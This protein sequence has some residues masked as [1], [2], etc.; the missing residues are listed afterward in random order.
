MTWRRMICLLALAGLIVAAL[1]ACAQEDTPAGTP[2]I[3]PITPAASLPTSAAPVASPASTAGSSPA[4][5]T[6]PGAAY[7]AGT[8]T[9]TGSLAAYPAPQTETAVPGYTVRVINRYPHDPDAFTQGLLWH[10]GVLYESTGS[11]P[12][13]SSLRQVNLEDGEVLQIHTLPQSYFGEGLVLWQD[14]LIQLTW[15][16]R[17]AFVYDRDSF[18]ILAEWSYATEGW[19][20]T[21]D[22]RRLIMSD[23]S[24]TLF[25]RDPETFA[26]VGRVQVADD[27]GPVVRLNELE[28]INGE[29]WANIWQT[30][31]IARIDPETGRVVG[32]IDLAGLLDRSNLEQP[33]DV[34]NGIAYDA[35][36]DR[37]FVTGKLWPT[38]FEVEL[39][40]LDS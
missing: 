7:P 26:E 28:Y 15:K 36:N 5:P 21:H 9:H 14:K 29:V 32:W 30:D 40:P 25:F 1:A 18:A 13:A 12:T 22:G 31:R 4:A 33:G 16:S 38:L 39:V 20:I 34:L 17:T 10:E 23:G 11:I 37:I 19:G 2:S 3:I 6:V 35:E 27:R 8:S 24:D